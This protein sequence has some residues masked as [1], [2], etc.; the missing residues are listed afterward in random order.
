MNFNIRFFIDIFFVLSIIYLNRNRYYIVQR[1]EFVHR[2]YRIFDFIVQF[3]I[4]MK[5]ENHIV[6]IHFI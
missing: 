5:C 2:D 4:K 3:F 6:L 1:F